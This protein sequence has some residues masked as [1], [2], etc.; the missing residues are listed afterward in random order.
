MRRSLSHLSKKPAALSVAVLGAL[1]LVG[2]VLTLSAGACQAVPVD[3]GPGSR[4]IAP[5]GVIEGTVLYQGPH[6]CSENG[7]IVGN[8]ILLFF[9]QSEPPP[10]AGIASTAVNFA[11]IQGDLLF[12]D[13]PVS[14]ATG[15]YCPL[16]HGNTETIT[17]SAPF[18]VSPFSAGTYIIEAFFDYQ[19]AFLPT[20]KF[21]ELPEMGDIAGGYIDTT[22]AILHA[23]AGVDY[24]AIFLPVTVGVPLGTVDAGPDAQTGIG[25]VPPRSTVDS[26]P[27]DSGPDGSPVVLPDGGTLVLPQSGFVANNITVSVG[28]VLPLARPYFYAAGA[29]GPASSTLVTSANPSGNVNYVPAATMAQDIQILAQPPLTDANL[30]ND[31]TPFQN[32]L[33]SIKLLAGVPSDELDTAIDPNGP[34]Q[35]QLTPSTDTTSLFTWTDG[36]AIPESSLIANLLPQVVFTKLIDDPTHT[37]DPQGIIQQVPPAGPAVLIL[38][39]TLGPTD[40]IQDLIGYKIT[41]PGP[42]AVTDHVTALVRPLAICVDPTHPELGATL[43]APHLT[44]LSADPKTSG[45]QALFNTANVIAAL[46]PVVGRVNPE[47]VIGCLPPGRYAPNLVYPTG[48]AWTVPNES[49]SCAAT[50]GSIEPTSSSPTGAACAGDAGIGRSVLSSQGPRA[51]LEITASDSALCQMHPPP[52]VCL[53]ASTTASP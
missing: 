25:P 9:N 42:T 23:N 14:G 1:A 41:A 21:R 47:P 27:V 20:F 6:P 5:T 10:P 24:K 51:V 11:S 7:H 8:L 37:L 44:G 29:T 34:F 13:E 45:Q 22:D 52:S 12:Q 35:F 30:L 50:E 32:S 2:L 43:V 28:S 19:G 46:T 31:I 40:R 53:A 38:G 3:N 39:L 15:R 18:T 26:G 17:A 33:A 49:G 16:D 36:T 48:E 4:V